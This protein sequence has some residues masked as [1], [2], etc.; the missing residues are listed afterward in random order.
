MTWNVQFHPFHNFSN[1][2]PPKQLVFGQISKFFI[3]GGEGGTLAKFSQICNF[4]N[5]FQL[6]NDPQRPILP[7]K[8]LRLAQNGQFWSIFNFSQVS[9]PKKQ[10]RLTQNGKFHLICNFSNLF[11]PKQLIFGKISKFFIWGG[12]SNFGYVKSA[13]SKEAVGLMAQLSM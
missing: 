10:L 2:F 3:F 5:H 7:P 1:L 11:P 8:W 9:P 13:I 6:E 4:L 12:T